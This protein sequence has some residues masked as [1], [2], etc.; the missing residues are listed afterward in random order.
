MSTSR[1]VPVQS[2][3]APFYHHA[4][5]YAIKKPQRTFSGFVIDFKLPS[6]YDAT[7]AERLHVTVWNPFKSL[8]AYIFLCQT[9][10]RICGCLIFLLCTLLWVVLCTDTLCCI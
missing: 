7:V 9:V 8:T 6:D 2:V 1:Y 4:N 3:S 10:N 5:F